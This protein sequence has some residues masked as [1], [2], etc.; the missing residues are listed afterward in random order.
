[1]TLRLLGR[2]PTWAGRGRLRVADSESPIQ[3]SR[4]RVGTIQSPPIQST[5]KR[6][7]F[8]VRRLDYPKN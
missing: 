1:M 2:A 6:G 3:S 8:R 4:F 5:W 7:R